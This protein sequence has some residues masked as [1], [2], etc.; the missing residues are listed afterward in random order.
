MAMTRPGWRWRLA[1]WGWALLGTF[2]R[3][4]PRLA[5]AERSLSFILSLS[6]THSNSTTTS[7]LNP[8]HNPVTNQLDQVNII[9]WI[10]VS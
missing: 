4:R 10:C 8:H 6:L 1:H 2:D 9:H 5:K 7:Q 3:P